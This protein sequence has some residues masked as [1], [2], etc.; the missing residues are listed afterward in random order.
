[1]NALIPQRDLPR[2]L[3]AALSGGFALFIGIVLVWTIGYQLAYA[4]RIFPGVSVAGVDLSGLSPGEAAVKL[5]Q[6][7]SYPNTG[8]LLFRDGE[9]VWVASPAEL[10]MVFDPTASANAAYEHGRKGGMFTALSR[11]ISARGLGADVAPVVIF[12]QRV[13]YAYLQ[14]LAVQVDQPLAE[15]VLRLEGTNVISEPGRVGRSLNLDAT[16]IYL[17]SQLQSFRDGEVPLV[18]QETTPRLLDVNAQADLAR[19]MLS[20][21]FTVTLPNT[22]SND[23]G[24]WT[25]D[26]NVLVNMLAFNMIDSGGV[27]QLQVGL[28]AN[29][30]RKSLSDL[31]VLVDRTPKEPRFVFDESRGQIEPISDSSVGRV[32]DVEASI[33]A[34]NGA[35]QRGEHSVN[36][37]VAEQQPAV[38]DQANGAELGIIQLV[39]SQTTY[40]YGSSE[41]RIQ[42]I[43]TAASQYHGLLVAPG[44]TFSMGSVLGDVSLENGYA[45]A[46]IIYGGRTIKGVGGGVCQVS[47][48]LFRTV[49]F[50]GFP[51]VER[52]SHAYRVPYYEMDASGHV[53]TQ[54]AGMDATVY[55]PLVDFKFTN[56]TPYWMLMETYVDVGARTLT[57]KI[58]STSDGRSVTWETTGPQNTLPAPEPVLEENP[59]MRVN[60]IKQVDYAAEGAD[61]NV[62]RTVWRNGQIYFTDQFQTHYEP[63]AAVCQYGPGTED[64]KK[65]AKKSELCAGSS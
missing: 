33:A 2:Q 22:G 11:Q 23:P 31:K 37:V 61:V 39:A 5:S 18:I 38:T 26:V 20:Q 21:P 44:Q 50:A 30:L 45:E 14:N 17:G 59:D 10:G 49:F 64:P 13:A 51:V 24:P 48:T 19:T 60:E 63:W 28:D 1:M 9:R 36:L 43:V 6:T 40:F 12:D 3:L 25:F 7:L 56:D 15:A 32:M 41:A 4:G 55:V 29:A 34:I 16:L 53:D 62:T 27:P 52:Y 54:F 8:K 47:T 58:Y 57:W 65:L 35:L 42:N 46:L